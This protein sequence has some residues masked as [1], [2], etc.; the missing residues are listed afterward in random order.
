M[1]ISKGLQAGTLSVAKDYDIMDVKKR[2]N[3]VVS[4]AFN[5]LLERGLYGNMA[6]LSGRINDIYNLFCPSLKRTRERR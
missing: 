5:I 2:M 6:F 1:V 3:D 4:H